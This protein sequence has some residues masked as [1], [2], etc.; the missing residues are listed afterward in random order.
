MSTRTHGHRQAK[1][2]GATWNRHPGRSVPECNWRIINA[3]HSRKCRRQCRYMIFQ[4]GHAS[5]LMEPSLR[6]LGLTLMDIL[7][8]DSVWDLLA[9][10]CLHTNAPPVVTTKESQSPQ[11]I[12]S[13]AHQSLAMCKLFPPPSCPSPV[14]LPPSQVY[15]NTAGVCSCGQGLIPVRSLKTEASGTPQHG[16]H[17]AGHRKG[18]RQYAT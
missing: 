14:H 9:F 17:N 4:S 6:P 10:E 13:P 2:N 1:C 5:Q 15:A 11:R 8:N 7:P 16:S 18:G 3:G 12:I